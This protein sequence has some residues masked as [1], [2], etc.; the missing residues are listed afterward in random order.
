MDLHLS[1][2]SPIYHY[3]LVQ[4]NIMAYKNNQ[5]NL[6]V[7]YIIVEVSEVVTCSFT[8]I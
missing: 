1:N 6:S 5:N 8:M 4:G 2:S 7:F 3:E